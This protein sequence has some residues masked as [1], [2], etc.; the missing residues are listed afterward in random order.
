MLYLFIVFGKNYLIVHFIVTNFN[1][2]IPHF[3]GRCGPIFTEVMANTWFFKKSVYLLKSCSKSYEILGE[4]SSSQAKSFGQVTILATEGFSSYKNSNFGPFLVKKKFLEKIKN[5][6]FFFFKIQFY[7]L[8][9]CTLGFSGEYV[10]SS[11][12][13]ERNFEAKI[14]C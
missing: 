9:L 13:R 6:N 8:F 14:R 7:I 10:A 3:V 5:F 12:K 11:P 1:S 2:Y 4:T